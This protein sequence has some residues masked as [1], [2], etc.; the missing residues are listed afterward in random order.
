[1]RVHHAAADAGVIRRPFTGL[2]HDGSACGDYSTPLRISADVDRVPHPTAPPE[3][4]RVTSHQPVHDDRSHEGQDQ[5]GN[6]DCKHNE[7]TTRQG[8]VAER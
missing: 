5:D 4:A 6:E 8:Q 3:S 7:E 2:P 1:M